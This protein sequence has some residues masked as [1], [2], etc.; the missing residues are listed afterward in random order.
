LGF[1]GYY[2]GG[3]VWLP[4]DD[5]MTRAQRVSGLPDLG[6]MLST[7]NTD[8]FLG[9]WKMLAAGSM[10]F[11]TILG[12][13]LLGEGLRLRLSAER[14]S[15]R[16]TI[17]SQITE[18]L[19]AGIEEKVV[20]PVLAQTRRRRIAGAVASLLIV[21]IAAA[22]IWRQCGLISPTAGGILA[23]GVGTQAAKLTIPG[24][25]PWGTERHDP[26]G[27][28]QTDAPEL[29]TA[30]IQWGF[31]DPAGF[32]GGPA[33]SS[34]GTIF[35]AAK[36]K[37]LYALNDAGTP[38]W[39][40]A[41][42]AVPVG[43]PALG[44]DGRI[45]VADRAGGLSAF[46]PDGRLEWRM[47]SS[48]ELEATGSPIVAPDGTIY[49]AIAG[50]VQ[51]VSPGGQ[52]LWIADAYPLRVSTPPSLSPGRDLVFLK[53][54]AVNAK[55]GAL[56]TYESP[57]ER[58]DQYIVGADSRVYRRDENILVEWGLS[59]S[60]PQMARHIEWDFRRNI[61]MSTV[62]SD[63]GM[64]EG[65]MI[66][67]LYTLDTVDASL[68]WLDKSGQVLGVAR[69]PQR[70]ARIVAIDGRSTAY[71]CGR[72][73]SGPAECRAFRSPSEDPL[74]ELTLDKGSTVVGGAL[75]S[76]RLYVTME[77]GHFYAIGQRAVD[78]QGGAAQPIRSTPFRDTG[79]QAT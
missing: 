42:P 28:L 56:Q 52:P 26:Y 76:G 43:T 73:R 12:F 16:E 25:H 59:E 40:A 78:T 35:V 36:S 31:D 49:Y 44:T 48:D 75:V 63:A 70:E 41:L 27:T 15:R 34:D 55:N 67:L 13:N 7:L 21:I 51:A 47:E 74:W 68:I 1:L 64:T 19:G 33:V 10:V 18:C 32:G 69:Y 54:G 53:N 3:E 5:F 17:L 60:N 65:G 23:D 62:P 8:V 58:F 2:L 38:L 20:T 46:A 11:I 79:G 39:R 71:T 50:S 77:E 66:W 61:L 37:T 57:G 22:L 6:L 72:H 30:R 45:Y 4:L 29:K 24:A 9:P 14:V